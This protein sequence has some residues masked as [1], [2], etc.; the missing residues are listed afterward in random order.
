MAA[1]IF[2]QRF[3]I[4]IVVADSVA[5]SITKIRIDNRQLASC[6]LPI[7]KTAIIDTRVQIVIYAPGTK[8]NQVLA[9]FQK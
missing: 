5:D 3:P 1:A 9:L 2:W 8:T 7:R 4:K 6:R